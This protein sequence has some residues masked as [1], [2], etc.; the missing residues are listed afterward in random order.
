MLKKLA[1]SIAVLATL[2][3]S[4]LELSSQSSFGYQSPRYVKLAH[5]ITDKTAKKLKDQKNLILIGTGGKMMDDIQ[6]MDMSFNYYQVVNLEEARKLIGFIISE[7]LS[8]INNNQEIRPYLHEYPFTAKN[9][10]IRIFIYN[11]DRSKVSPE[12][13]YY[14]SAIDGIIDYYIRGPEK[15]SR[16]A[17]QEETYE[18]ARAI[19]NKSMTN[20]QRKV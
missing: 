15:Y 7:Y 4:T 16:K 11:L 12:K 5:E 9:V 8:D 20:S 18:E 6:A 19:L 2:V 17:I 13:I 3:L 1:I 10:E 14:V